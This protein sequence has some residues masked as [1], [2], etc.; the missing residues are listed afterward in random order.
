MNVNRKYF[1]LCLYFIVSIPLFSQSMYLEINLNNV[2][3][4]GSLFARSKPRLEIFRVIEKAA[5]DNNVRGIILNIGSVSRS[6]DYCWELRSALEQFKSSG[7][8][9]YAF[10][11]NANM[12]IYMLASVADKIIMD[13][14]GSLSLFGYSISRGYVRQTLEKL[15]IGVREFRFFE[16]KSALETFTRDSMS[17][18]DRRQSS[19]FLDDIFNYT[20]D[21]LINA[22]NW[23]TEEFDTIINREFLYSARNA[24]SR[25][26]V[27][28]IG[29]KNAV[30]EAIKELEGEEAKRFSLYGDPASS[31][32]GT[33]VVYSAPRGRRFFSRPPVI[34]VVY[35]EGQTDME[36]GMAA[37]NL[38]R[39]IRN[40]ADNGRVK[41]IVVRINSPGGS[42]EAAD[43]LDE[44]VRYA[45]GKKPVVVSMG[46]MAAS[47]GYWAAMNANHIFATP[48]T[49]TG[50]IGVIG[51]WFYDNGLASRFGLSMETIQRGDHADLYTGFIVPYR[52]F[53]ELE[54]E[55]Y[56]NFILDIYTS[57]TEKVAV[58]RNMDLE[59]VE[60]AARGRIFSGTRA[61]EVGLIDSIG[62]L[63][64]ALQMARK[65]AEIPEGRTVVYREFPEPGFFDNLMNRFPMMAALF[66]KNS[67]QTTAILPFV[68]LLLPDA[69]IRYRLEN[70][71]RVMPI[72]PLEFYGF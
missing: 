71:G 39:T 72:L 18:A 61:L 25:N 65:L 53:T 3:G 50:S 62:S 43:L 11:S 41:A 14:Q 5:N 12:D 13:E 34:A 20:R 69:D 4:G 28:H 70:N 63:S 58:G 19:D 30:L 21:V 68:D 24:H 37:V 51:S 7:K 31:L 35:A 59:K 29:R 8:K 46:Q 48:Y 38:S 15:G 32:T 54:E 26:L 47:G 23:T 40:L 1:L 64:D 45:K 57:F 60:A 52:D 9:V 17:E 44:A 42:P 36:R 67:S 66:R 33:K 49:L 2:R 56:R 27:D 22:R 55:R 6:R 10:I 16:Y